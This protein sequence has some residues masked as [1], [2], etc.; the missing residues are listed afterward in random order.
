MS[1]PLCWVNNTI[2]KIMCVFTYTYSQYTTICQ[3]VSLCN[4]Q[5][6]IIYNNYMFRPCKWAIIRLTHN[7]AAVFTTHNSSSD[8]KDSPAGYSRH[9]TQQSYPNQEYSET[10]RTI[11][12]TTAPLQH[13]RPD[14]HAA[15]PHRTPYARK[16]QKSRHHTRPRERFPPLYTTITNKNAGKI[17]HIG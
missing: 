6:Y 4:K 1:S 5:H 9:V 12:H 10:E 17:A 14:K 7:S 11:P 8:Y 16:Q 13:R 3:I 2:Y 15:H